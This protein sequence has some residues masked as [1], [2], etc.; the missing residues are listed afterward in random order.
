[1]KKTARYCSVAFPYGCVLVVVLVSF[2]LCGCGPVVIKD[3]GPSLVTVMKEDPRDTSRYLRLSSAELAGEVTVYRDGSR[4][5]VS[6]P[7]ELLPGDVIETG[8]G[9]AAVV[10]FPDSNKII[11]DS[12]TRA[13]LGSFFVEFGRVLAR[14]KGFFEAESE[15]ITAGV[16]GTEFVFEVTRDRS[17]AV[18]VL[19]GTVVCR[20]KIRSWQERLSASEIFYSRHPNLVNPG[21]RPATSKELDDIRRWM[22]KIEESTEPAQPEPGKSPPLLITPRPKPITPTPKPKDPYR[23]PVLR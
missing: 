3:R 2:T 20:S 18:T 6:L 16:E 4:L 14:V 22:K 13:R 21:R 19:D 7:Y 8:P 10:H 17:V 23:S 12:N 1:M 11:L 15:N 5:P 9:A